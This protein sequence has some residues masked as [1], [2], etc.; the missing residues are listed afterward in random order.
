M[1]IS[2][3]ACDECRINVANQFINGGTCD[4]AQNNF[5][6]G[7]NTTCMNVCGHCID[8]LDFYFTCDVL[9]KSNGNCS[10]DCNTTTTTTP[11]TSPMNDDDEPWCSNE[12]SDFAVCVTQD[13]DTD[14]EGID[15]DNCRINTETSSLLTS[16]TTTTTTTITNSN[17]TATTCTNLQ[18]EVCNEMIPTCADVCSKE[19]NPCLKESN[20]YKER[21]EKVMKDKQL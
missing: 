16:T 12:L 10:I 11:S 20:P 19:S 7:I 8:E 9:D 17:A 5:C 4:A 1:I 15:C 18:Q 6:Y 3:K 13:L 2:G 21:K 14:T